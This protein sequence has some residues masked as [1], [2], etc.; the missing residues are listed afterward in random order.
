MCRRVTTPYRLPP[1]LGA[2]VKFTMHRL[3]I[4]LCL[5]RNR[6]IVN[7]KSIQRTREVHTMKNIE[8]YLVNKTTAAFLALMA[9]SNTAFASG[10]ES[11]T[12]GKKLTELG[13]FI[14]SEIALPLG[15]LVIIGL[16][17]T[18]MK[19]NSGQFTGY[20]VKAVAGLTVIVAAASIAAWIIGK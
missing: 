8:N 12:I 20:A 18:I 2:L 11:W 17:I 1:V 4:P 10:L 16:G 7:L 5:Y 13:E 15:V 3:T 9:M 6:Y 19:G 14:I